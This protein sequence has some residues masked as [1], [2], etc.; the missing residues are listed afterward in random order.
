M[1][2]ALHR[3][4]HKI[5]FLEFES[6]REMA[7]ALLRF[8]EYYECP[9][10]RGRVFTLRE[11]KEWYRG[12]YG[13]FTYLTDWVGFN[14]PCTVLDPFLQG[15]FRPLRKAE[16]EILGLLK[17]L[18]RPFYV[19]ATEG[20]RPSWTPS[21]NKAAKGRPARRSIPHSDASPARP[22]PAKQL[23][24]TLRH[25]LAHALYHVSAGYRQAVQDLLVDDL[26]LLTQEVRRMGDYADRVLAD[27]VQ[28]YLVGNSGA[29][30][31]SPK[32]IGQVGELFEQY[33]TGSAKASRR[34]SPSAAQTRRSRT[35]RIAKG[36]SRVSSD[37]KR[38]RKG[39][40]C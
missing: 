3:P 20:I 37:R 13:R 34:P 40:R 12:Q 9:R 26:P 25:E 29:L 16:L 5:V 4:F 11:Y 39:K 23:R 6:Q 2:I 30:Q 14:F 15:R 22:H 24:T 33:L 18:R 36:Q 27:E 28:A 32:L 19:I 38:K 8:Q 10:F 7:A 35:G 1:D 21:G 17:L 31:V